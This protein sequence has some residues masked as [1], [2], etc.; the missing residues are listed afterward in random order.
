M[1]HGLDPSSTTIA[2]T[3]KQFPGLKN[4]ACFK[5]DADG[6]DGCIQYT[7]SCTRYT[8]EAYGTNSFSRGRAAGAGRLAHR[9]GL[10]P[11]PDPPES[12][13]RH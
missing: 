13:R 7:V 9:S 4:G 3:Q 5:T 6:G 11:S 2:R 8:S 1:L 10:E 12:G